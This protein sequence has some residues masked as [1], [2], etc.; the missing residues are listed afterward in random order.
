MLAQFVHLRQK[1]TS[2]IWAVHPLSDGCRFAPCAGKTDRGRAVGT[3]P[4]RIARPPVSPAPCEKLVHDPVNFHEN[5][6]ERF[7]RVHDDV[8]LAKRLFET[9]LVVEASGDF[10]PGRPAFFQEPSFPFTSRRAKRDHE[11]DIE[12]GHH[13]EKQCR[14]HDGKGNT[15]RLELED[16]LPANLQHGGVEDGVELLEGPAVAEHDPAELLAVHAIAGEYDP[17][18]PF[19]HR[20]T[21]PLVVRQKVVS[22]A[23]RVDVTR[24]PR[25]EVGGDRGFPRPRTADEP[26]DLHRGLTPP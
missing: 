20:S 14:V 18:E 16:P 13:L 19:F 7:P 5:G 22:D 3:G 12:G 4:P 24:P 17:A 8:G 11:I 10:F 25:R 2:L 26:D 9:R 1:T 15:S 23:I 6:R 21:D